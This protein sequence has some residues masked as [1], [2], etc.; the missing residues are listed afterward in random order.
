[1][2]YESMEIYISRIQPQFYLVS[3]LVDW[4]EAMENTSSFQDFQIEIQLARIKTMTNVSIPKNMHLSHCAYE[5]SSWYLKTNVANC[6]IMNL[7]FPRSP[8]TAVRNGVSKNI[9]VY[10]VK[11]EIKFIL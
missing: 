1:M 9:V 5:I 10:V 6:V 2:P 7:S 4:E 3:V 8:F 11:E